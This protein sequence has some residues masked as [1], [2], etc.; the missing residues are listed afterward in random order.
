MRAKF[1]LS[2]KSIFIAFIISCFFT[3]PLDAQNNSNSVSINWDKPVMVSK[4]TPTL[5]LV[6]NPM[7]RPN[8]AIH[9]NTFKALK[10]LGANHVRYAPWF[11][12]LRWRWQN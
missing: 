11:L 7:V 2:N 4:T 5:Q 9:E 10:E 6:E 3:S 8:S 1:I 12:Y